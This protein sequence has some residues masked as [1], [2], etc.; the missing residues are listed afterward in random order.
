MAVI[1]RAFL[2]LSVETGKFRAGI[3]ESLQ[4]VANMEK[5]LSPAGKRMVQ[6]FESALNPA[7]KLAEKLEILERAGK[8]MVDI[9]LVMGKRIDE[10]TAIMK[11]HGQVLP[12]I[13]KS[14]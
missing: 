9:N 4:I 5:K 12:D 10:T 8:S 6:S 11:A 1:G 13:V 3:E 2:E 7:I 14:Y